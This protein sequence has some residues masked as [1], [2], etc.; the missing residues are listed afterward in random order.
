M[1]RNYSLTLVA[2]S[3]RLPYSILH[4][5]HLAGHGSQSV[6]GV[7]AVV[8]EVLEI[9]IWVGLTANLVIAEWI[10]LSRIKR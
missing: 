3:A 5:D 10:I 9:N 1:V 2:A 4:P 8:K 7:A 6:G